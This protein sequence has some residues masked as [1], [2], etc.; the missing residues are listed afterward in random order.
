M[1]TMKTIEGS[2]AIFT[3]SSPGVCVRRCSCG[4]RLFCFWRLR[5]QYSCNMVKDDIDQNKSNSCFKD[6]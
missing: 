4:Q 2:C 1:K 3:D 5:M 6:Q